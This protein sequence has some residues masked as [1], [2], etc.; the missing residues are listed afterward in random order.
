VRNVEILARMSQ[1]GNVTFQMF[2]KKLMDILALD[3]PSVH[4]EKRELIL[5]AINQVTVKI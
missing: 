2:F 5:D 4:Y 3:L 1:L